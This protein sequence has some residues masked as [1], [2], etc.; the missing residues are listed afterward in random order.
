[1]PRMFTNLRREFFAS[2]AFV[3]MVCGSGCFESTRFEPGV[4]LMDAAAPDLGMDSGDTGSPDTRIPAMDS[5]PVPADAGPPSDA[6]VDAS[7][8]EA[9]E[10]L[11]PYTGPRCAESVR[12]CFEECAGDPDDPGFC[13]D[14]CI[15]SDPRCVECI[16]ESVVRC[17]A[18][19]GCQ[20]PWDSFA[21]CSE[22]AGCPGRVGAQ[23]LECADACLGEIEA[24]A[25]CLNERAAARC[26]MELQRCVEG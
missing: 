5:G 25:E 20:E 15:G 1:M 24:F 6:P 22:E 9:G 12:N 4:T 3:V 2:F 23:R 14:E 13:E 17:A 19:N 16:N 18:N 21:C 11:E 8:C 26:E 10:V 7:A